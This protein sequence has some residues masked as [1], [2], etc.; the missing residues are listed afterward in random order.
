MN[1]LTLYPL[2]ELLIVVEAVRDLIGFRIGIHKLF[3]VS[4]WFEY[5]NEMHPCSWSE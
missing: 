2:Y 4:L 1:S 5:K 3:V